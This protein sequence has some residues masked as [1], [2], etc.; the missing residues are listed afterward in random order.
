MSI[1]LFEEY[2]LILGIGGLILYMLYIIYKLGSE[3]KAGR[4]GFII[5][6]IALGLGFVGLIVKWVLVEL[7]DL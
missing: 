1:E 7:M 4:F 2:S 3:S 5:L 6:F